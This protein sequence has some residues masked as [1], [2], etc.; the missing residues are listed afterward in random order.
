MGALRKIALE[1]KLLCGVKHIRVPCRRCKGMIWVSKS[2]FRGF[3]KLDYN[4]RECLGIGVYGVGLNRSS[5]IDED[6][7]GTRR[8]DV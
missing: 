1:E 4:C 6:Y 2:S 3:P 8:D 5:T 7:H